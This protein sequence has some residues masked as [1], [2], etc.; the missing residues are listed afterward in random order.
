MHAKQC[1]SLAY[2]AHDLN[3]LDSLPASAYSYPIQHAWFFPGNLG[4]ARHTKLFA[5]FS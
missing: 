4:C 2:D 3:Q 1:S 5:C